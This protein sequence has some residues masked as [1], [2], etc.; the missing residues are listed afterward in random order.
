MTETAPIALFVFNRPTH[1]R[2]TLE[3]LSS[4][5]LSKDSELWIFSDGPKPNDS[6]TNISKINE[7]RKII[8]EKKWC[9]KVNIIESSLNKGL[10]K[11]IIDG[12]TTILKDNPKII[13]L[14]DDLVVSPFFLKYINTA[15]DK[16]RDIKEIMQICSYMFPIDHH[17]LNETFFLHL[18]SSWG[19]ATWSRAWEFFE[20]DIDKILNTFPENQI[21]RFNLDGAY[22]YF[23]F[24]RLQQENKIDSWAI[25][26]YA[27]VFLNNGVCLHPSRSLVK[28]IGHD[29]SGTHTRST[30]FYDNILLNHPINY[31]ENQIKE[32]QGARQKIINFL[33]HASASTP[34]AESFYGRLFKNMKSIITKS[35]NAK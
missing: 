34:K 7:V 12:V 5:D 28:N 20:Y 26:W 31:F 8:R 3:S 13:V 24:F 14:E 2:L 30:N 11:S 35:A 29:D 18:T 15:L 27:T 25:R 10:S 1:T 22:D 6:L 9:Q 23:S 21:N 16:Y 33:K 19:W 32:D 17:G 4:N